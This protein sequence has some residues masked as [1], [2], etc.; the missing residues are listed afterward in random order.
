MELNT[1]GTTKCMPDFAGGAHA[2]HHTV[3]SALMSL[4]AMGVGAHRISLRQGG[5]NALAAGLVLRQTP[6]AGEPVTE[7]TEITL[8]IA[9]LGFTHALPVGMWDS[10]GEA[11][12]GTREILE[13]VDDPLVKLKHWF[14]DGAPLFRIASGDPQ[15]CARWL[16]L[17]GIDAQQWP[18][19]LWYPLASAMAQVPQIACSED[20]CG[21]LLQTLLGLQVRST[22]YRPCQVS[23]PDTALSR[24]G[25]KASRLGVDM[26]LGDAAEDLA[27]LEIEIGPV[28]LST[29]TKYAETREGEVLLR[30]VLELALPMSTNYEVRWTVEDLRQAPQLGFAEKN[31]RLGI[32]THLGGS[33]PVPQAVIAHNHS[34]LTHVALEDM[35]GS[36]L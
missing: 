21:V 2:H 33:L 17:F 19:T 27:T 8:D 11:A 18:M 32:N 10:G 20:G 5:R 25:S 1:P 13:A 3:H 15:A 28:P 4:Q 26:L 30:R 34:D 23:L 9:G 36:Q 14:H 6:S 12:A 24:L 22:R 31:A 35:V 29:F 16:A 7:A